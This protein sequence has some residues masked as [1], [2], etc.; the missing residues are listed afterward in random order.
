M[1]RLNGMNLEA[2][3]DGGNKAAIGKRSGLIGL[4]ALVSLVATSCGGDGGG[5]RPR[6]QIPGAAQAAPEEATEDPTKDQFVTLGENPKWVPLRD[7]FEDFKKQ[8]IE[9]LANPLLT[10]HV[11]FVIPPP[12]PER[13]K[14]ELL[15]PVSPLERG[16]IHRNKDKDQRA[17]APL[18]SYKLIML[19]TGTTRPKA[20][21]IDPYGNRHILKRGDPLGSEGGYIRAIL[22]YKMLV[23]VPKERKP[24]SVSIEPPLSKVAQKAIVRT[25]F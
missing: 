25:D 3:T 20:V 24:R 13:K 12:L 6:P 7:M 14:K 17:I 9:N 1:T 8:K 16:G 19:M 4:A 5:N 23:S 11:V 10:N 21:V 22:Q 15:V 2:M 18:E